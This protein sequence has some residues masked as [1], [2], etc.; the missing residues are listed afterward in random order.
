MRVVARWPLPSRSD[1]RLASGLTLLAYATSHLANHAL[2]LYSMAAAEAALRV[3][4]GVWHSLPG[5]LLLVLAATVHVALAFLALFERRTLRMPTIEAIRYT[6]GFAIPLILIAHVFGTRIAAVHGASPEYERIVWQ[7]ARNDNEWRQLV[8]IA[9]VWVHAM[10]GLTLWLR[11]RAWFPRWSHALLVVAC[12]LPLL[13][14]LG[15]LSMTRELTLRADDPDVITAQAGYDLE[16]DQATRARIVDQRESWWWGYVALLTAV[17]AARIG[18]RVVEASRRTTITLRYPDAVV[19]VP[20][21]FTVLE[22]SRAHAIPHLSLC[23]GRGR[24]S[25]C[26]VRVA[27]REGLPAPLPDE[28]ATLASIRAPAD[29]RLACQLK[30]MHDLAVA[31]VFAI[32]GSFAPAGQGS[33]EREIV[34]LFTDLRRWTGLAERQLPFDLVYVQNQFYGAVGDAVV[35]AGGLPNQFIGDS[36]MAIFGLGVAF[37]EACR[38]A[39]VAVSAIETRMREVNARIKREFAHTLDFG[40]GLHGGPAVV[41]EVGYRDTRTVSAVG[42]TVNIAARL[43]ELTKTYGARI[44]LSE[45]VAT[46][47]AWNLAGHAVHAIEVRGRQAPLSVFAL[48]AGE[49]LASRAQAP[50]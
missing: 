24:C 31:P 12:L 11:H 13:G 4:V 10:I 26:R 23:G 36:V 35:E 30:P 50:V 46:G 18:R 34:V 7:I 22:A 27:P 9:L 38:Q 29:V 44:V 6:L 2:G 42:D 25:T 33:V 8:L 48:A 32:D 20:R 15:F 28:A 39:L 3:A 45:V 49:T 17:L 19:Q 21:G 47:A 5:T 37:D 40:I 16:V 14:L 43:Q 1:L 41:G